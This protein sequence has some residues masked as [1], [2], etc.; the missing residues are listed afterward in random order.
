MC[1]TGMILL[2]QILCSLITKIETQNS[3]QGLIGLTRLKKTVACL[4]VLSHEVSGRPDSLLLSFLVEH[5]SPS[6]FMTD[7]MWKDWRELVSSYN[8]GAPHSSSLSFER[9]LLQKLVCRK[10]TIDVA[11]AVSWVPG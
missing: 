9:R 8:L 2:I 3:G 5:P 7:G 11:L 1:K 6:S 4:Q 10:L